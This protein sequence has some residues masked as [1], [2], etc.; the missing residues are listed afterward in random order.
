MKM[1]EVV[2]PS[3]NQPKQKGKKFHDFI[4]PCFHFQIEIVV[5]P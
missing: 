3:I 1:V 4:I 5:G 2:V